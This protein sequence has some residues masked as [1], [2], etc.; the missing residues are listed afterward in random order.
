MRYKKKRIYLSPPYLN[1]EE[2]SSVNKAIKSNWIAPLGPYVDKFENEILNYIK[3]KHAIAV[4]SGTAA[5]QLAM[6]VQTYTLQLAASC[7]GITIYMFACFMIF[8]F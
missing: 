4:S 5:L 3:I 8:F 2:I 1:D 7:N 6:K